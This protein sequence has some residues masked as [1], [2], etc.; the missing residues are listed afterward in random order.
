MVRLGS[1]SLGW[2][3][4]WSS[5]GL[6]ASYA[7]SHA[8]TC[9]VTTNLARQLSRPGTAPA[10]FII[11]ISQH[12]DSWATKWHGHKTMYPFQNHVCR[13]SERIL[14]MCILPYMYF[15]SCFS[16]HSPFVNSSLTVCI[17]C[18]DSSHRIVVYDLL[19][20]PAYLVFLTLV[21]HSLCGEGEW[22]YWS[23]DSSVS[24]PT[25]ASMY[26][27]ANSNKFDTNRAD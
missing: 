1:L 7:N 16:M 13:T 10:F 6:L 24:S 27:Q 23:R 5:W 3:L 18:L 26:K 22:Y 20:P 8:I 11:A 17:R 25:T 4:P 9:S 21:H 15:S 14:S 2:A 12:R 19:S